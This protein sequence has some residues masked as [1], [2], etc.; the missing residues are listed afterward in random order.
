MCALPKD[1][2]DF[3]LTTDGISIQWS[4]KFDGEKIS[5][6]Y[7]GSGFI[8]SLLPITVRQIVCNSICFASACH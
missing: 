8:V 5:H 4:I 7:G 6:K 2:K 1:L 3:Y